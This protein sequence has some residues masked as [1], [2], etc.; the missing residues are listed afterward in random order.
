MDKRRGAANSEGSAVPGVE[1]ISVAKER[2]G[3]VTICNGVVRRGLCSKG[4]AKNG[5]TTRGKGNE[6]KGPEKPWNRKAQTSEGKEKP[7]TEKYNK[8]K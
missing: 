2:H 7:R 6:T 5:G 8:K 4:K 1:L 3:A